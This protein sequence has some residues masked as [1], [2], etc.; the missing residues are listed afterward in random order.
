MNSNVSNPMKTKKMLPLLLSMSIPPMF[1]MLIQ[2]LYNIIDSIFV[3]Y[4]N[5][6]AL[7]AVSLV[8]PLQNIVSGVAIGFGVGV[9]AIV[10][11]NLGAKDKEAVN[12]TATHAMILSGIHCLLFIIIGFLVTKPFLRMFTS[13]ATILSWGTQYSYIVNCVS[14]GL[15]YMLVIEKI[16]QASGNMLIP[17][18]VQAIGCIVNIILDPIFI[19][20]MFGLPKMGVAGA[21]AATVIAQI[22]A[23]IV[24]VLIWKNR[25]NGIHLAFK[26]FRFDKSIIKRLYMIGIPS[27]VMLILPSLVVSLLNGILKDISV[28]AI[29]VLGI[30]F[31][32]QTFV[33]MPASGMV[34]AMR[35]IV[36]YNHGAGDRHRVHEAIRSGI[37]ICLVIMT[38]GTLVSMFFPSE[39]FSMFNADAQLLGIGVPALRIISTGFIV[40]TL[41]IILCG[42]FEA[43]G[44][45]TQSLILSML[46]QLIILVPVAFVLSRFMGLNGVWIAFPIAEI[47]TSVVAIFYRKKYIQ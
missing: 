38:L 37:L 13:D 12:K 44:M 29:A 25:D 14:F 41:S 36:S 34:Q 23:F 20:G 5:Q 46:R 16:Y 43:L 9:S 26:G 17:M 18:L 15:M 31:K 7:T 8:Y 27:A 2:S 30:Y 3:S 28:S 42:A 19:F 21:A 40:S 1:S 24:Y 39:I 35:P 4:I 45:G 22:V 11:M 33:Y 47:L 10:A 32:L 6:D